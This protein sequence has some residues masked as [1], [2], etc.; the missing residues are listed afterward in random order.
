MIICTIS[1]QFKCLLSTFKSIE[2]FN[3]IV[4]SDASSQMC[5][6]LSRRLSSWIILVLP[7]QSIFKKISILFLCIQIFVRGLQRVLTL[8]SSLVP[9]IKVSLQEP[10][11][12]P[13]DAWTIENILQIRKLSSSSS[14]LVAYH[15]I[16]DPS[17]ASICI[18]CPHSQ[19]KDIWTLATGTSNH[20]MTSTSNCS[21]Y[22]WS[23]TRTCTIIVIVI[24]L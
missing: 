14:K 19:R 2:T 18:K 15:N 16:I 21:R 8:A 6:R 12:E 3:T 23:A 9:A 5:L 17:I 24:Q 13:A 1:L 4:N 10:R 20:A 22:K 7:V 11:K